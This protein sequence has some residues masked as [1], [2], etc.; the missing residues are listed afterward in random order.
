MSQTSRSGLRRIAAIAAVALLAPTAGAQTVTLKNGLVYR[1]QVDKDNTVV[2]VFDPDGLRRVIL[3]D[4][5]IASVAP[6]TGSAKVAHFPI[7]QPL[8]VHAG[9]M[10]KAAFGIT[11]GP[12]DNS[13]RRPF[14]YFMKEDQKKPIAMQQAIIDL[15]PRVS[16]IR[17]VDGFWV[18]Q[19]A[20]STIPKSAVLGILAKADQ[21]NIEQRIEVC[22]FLI[23]AE[24]FTE[25]RLEVERLA[26]DFGKDPSVAEKMKNSRDLIRE[27]EGRVFLA[28]IDARRKAQQP[29]AVAAKLKSFPLDGMPADIVASVRDQ[30]RKDDGRSS[31]D[32]A[33]ADAVRRAA[34]EAKIEAKP[35]IL[36][37][38]EGLAEAPDAVRERFEAFEKGQAEGAKPGDLYA[39]AL[40][41]WIAGA[42]SAVKDPKDAEAIAKARDLARQYLASAEDGG[43]G[44]SSALEALRAIEVGGAPLTPALLTEIV[45]RMPPPLRDGAEV[46]A[47]KPALLRVRDE[48]NPDQP[49]EYAVLLP[50]EYS[51]LRS[52]PM[53]VA[54][55]GTGSPMDTL[56]WWSAEAQR[57]GF[58]VIAPEYQIR[59][60]PPGYNYTESEHAAVTLAL[61]DALKRFSADPDRVFLAGSLFGGDMAWDF[62]QAH[63]DLFAG[64]ATISGWPAK[65]VWATRPNLARVPFYVAMGDLAP[66]EADIVFGVFARPIIAKNY[67]FTYVEYYRRGLEDFPEEAG[68][69]MD[70]MAPRK[71]DPYPK[72]FEVVAA[73]DCDNRFYGVVVHEFAAGRT[74]DPAG[75]DPLGK[76][77]TKPASIKMDAKGSGT[78]LDLTASGIKHL[79]VWVGPKHVDFAKKLEIRVNGKTAYKAQPKPDFETMLED[80]RVRGDRSQI[81]WMKVGGQLGG[82]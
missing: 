34:E 48:P 66:A 11:V 5:K 58:I 38:L 14:S 55:H 63:P 77:I 25:A 26:K 13:G 16:K 24:W 6:E 37:M 42:D 12:W 69:A 80:V 51:P 56:G 59:G 70:W 23:Q 21:K 72:S 3:R 2:S 31:T 4:S 76:S 61:R 1:G 75:V 9:E 15:G 53:V 41:G 40:S 8:V 27:S 68:P 29:R 35:R 46:V 78:L 64:V 22:R 74:K 47:G 17:G 54:L 7:V 60:K 28:E 79:D 65:Y 62:G 82:R 18:G 81:Y 45:R 30:V 57:R 10:P 20:T 67:D 32:R 19:V 52:Y 36:E 43:A 49:S 73:R 71:R 44:R 39:L 33:L 50:L